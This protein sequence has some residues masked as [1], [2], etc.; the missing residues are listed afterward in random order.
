MKTMAPI[1]SNHQTPLWTRPLEKNAEN[2]AAL[3]ERGSPPTDSAIH[4]LPLDAERATTQISAN[5]DHFLSVRSHDENPEFDKALNQ[6]GLV[7][8]GNGTTVTFTGTSL[9]GTLTSNAEDRHTRISYDGPVVRY[10]TIHRDG[11]FTT[12]KLDLSDPN[13]SFILSTRSAD[14]SSVVIEKSQYFGATHSSATMLKEI[15]QRSESAVLREIFLDGTKS[16]TEVRRNILSEM[17]AALKDS[18]L[19]PGDSA[20]LQEFLDNPGAK[21]PRQLFDALSDLSRSYGANEKIS[22]MREKAALWQSIEDF[23]KLQADG[24][25]RSSEYY[26]SPQQLQTSAAA[27]NWDFDSTTGLPIADTVIVGAGPGGLATGYHLSESGTRTVIFEGGHVGQGF[28][29]AGAKSV[30]QL[31]T[32]GAASNLIYTANSNQLGVD[33]SM[34]RHLGENRKKCNEARSQ[35]YQASHEIQ[36]GV[37]NAQ[38]NEAG[39]A[40]NRA[41]LFEHMSHVAH[42]LALNYPDT[43]VSENTPVT[44]IKKIERGDTHLFEVTTERGHHILARSLVMATGFVGGDGEHARNLAQFQKLEDTPHSG[45]TVLQTD[46]DL[47]TDNDSIDKNLLV[48]S[49]RLIGRPEVRQQIKALPEGSRIS[50][51]GGGESATKGALEALHL[52]SNVTIDLYTSSPLEP[53]QTQVPTSVIAPAVTEASI[54]DKEVAKRSLATLENFG[55]PVTPATLQS[56]YELEAAGRVRIHELGKRFNEDTVAVEPKHTDSRPILSFTLKD[57]QAAQALKEQRENWIAAGLYGD[58]PPTEPAD[59]LPHADMVIVAAGYDKRSL[60]AGPL[61]QQLE[62][63]GLVELS[64]GE[65]VNGE[66]GLT[67][68]R[69]DKIA[70]NTAGAVSMAAD[71]AIPARAVRGYRLAQNFATKLPTRERPKE[72]IESQLPYADIDTAQQKELFNWEKSAVIDFID[73][74]GYDAESFQKRYQELEKIEDPQERAS[75]ELRTDAARLFGGP[76]QPL[77]ALMIRAGEVPESLT[78][79]ERLLWQKAQD[80]LARTQPDAVA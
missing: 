72:R 33:V 60:R 76:N 35:W 6:P 63:Q 56:L 64:G 7:D 55:T 74:G 79:A 20:K 50:V 42:G 8:Y 10:V 4:S 45:V 44:G 21:T 31:R 75:A 12:Q 32:N 3:A 71:T 26:I 34:Q 5:R 65:I 69:N 61:I 73:R 70:F 68:A 51:I 36:H 29:D 1:S 58:N 48:F 23:P 17:D 67:S 14:E 9:K 39:G 62:N 46:N 49:E 19:S 24:I 22:A 43:L 80:I 40:A 13:K 53:Y 37:S 47:F 27:Q 66:D 25:G 11:Q 77:A 18:Q 15:P 59:V 16:M 2:A 57:P 38:A 52:N 28:S 78:P 54:R 30:H 41:E